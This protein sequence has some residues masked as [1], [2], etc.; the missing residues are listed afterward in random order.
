VASGLVGAAAFVA[1]A[2]I[3]AEPR[4]LFQDE[5]AQIRGLR[6]GPARVVLWLSS[7]RP[8]DYSPGLHDRMPPLSYWVGQ[9]WGALFGFGEGSLRVMGVAL[10]AVAV[11]VTGWTA[12]TWTGRAVAGFAA[13]FVMGLAPIVVGEGPDIRPYPLFMC[14]CSISMAFWARAIQEEGAM[15][16]FRRMA[17]L[18]IALIL[19]MYTHFFGVIL[20]AA[21]TGSGLIWT[22]WRTRGWK[23]WLVAGLIVGASA[24]GLAPFLLG[25]VAVSGAVDPTKQAGIG[26]GSV[27]R[28]L[29]NLISAPVLSCRPWLL[30]P[31]A[32]GV[33]AVGVGL[34]GRGLRSRDE[35]GGSLWPPL[36]AL[37][38]GGLMVVAAGLASDKLEATRPTY[39]LWAMPLATLLAVSP[40]A[41]NSRGV[42]IVTS[43]GLAALVG[44][45]VL[46]EYELIR[47]RD[48]LDHG[49]DLFL[50]KT[51]EEVGPDRISVLYDE[52][53]WYAFGSIPVD[54]RFNQ[55]VRQYMSSGPGLVRPVDSDESENIA[56]DS[57]EADRVAV[58]GLGQASWKQVVGRSP[59]PL[60]P[61]RRAIGRAFEADK[62]WRRTMSTDHTAIGD[63]GNLWLLG[64]RLD[65]YERVEAENMNG[66]RMP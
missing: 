54:L 53:P 17:P 7:G 16:D 23:P 61:E 43:L 31:A 13:T 57:I 36:L 6:L 49:A 12:A 55:R 5:T 56:I 38:I 27:V 8:R 48:L 24:V 42:R 64:I 11:A 45:H 52:G 25:S 39:N 29:V 50:N 40:L 35:Q 66:S 9:G 22:A 47:H 37:A 34:A 65:V 28:L 32:V 15:S 4:G 21:L 41:A 59:E 1:A 60:I 26:A 33:S 3:F 51:I 58:V 2:L 14:L 18:V 62:R 44:S 19:A 20:G 46:A 63:A 30:I 10:T